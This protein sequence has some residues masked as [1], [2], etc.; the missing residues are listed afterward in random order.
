MSVMAWSEEEVGLITAATAQWHDMEILTRQAPE[1]ITITDNTKEMECLLVTGP[2]ARKILEPI[3]EGH[4]L[5]ASWL[6][7]SM[8]GTVAG[9]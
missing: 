4:D 5:S 7:I 2:N 3:T 6:S 8:E 1:G 9:L